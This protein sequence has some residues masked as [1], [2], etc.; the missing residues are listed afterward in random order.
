MSVIERRASIG[1]GV[2]IRDF[3]GV[4]DC[5]CV[6]EMMCKDGGMVLAV[7]INE[8]MLPHNHFGSLVCNFARGKLSHRKVFTEK[9]CSPIVSKIILV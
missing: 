7:S 3:V 4:C 9:V 5:V 2:R 8:P 6:Q 1:F